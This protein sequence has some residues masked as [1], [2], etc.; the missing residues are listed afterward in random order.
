MK[1]TRLKRNSIT[2]AISAALGIMASSAVN[3]EE[4]VERVSIIG[5][6]I[7][8]SASSAASPVDVIGSEYI[9]RS[10]AF[11][12]GEITAKLGVNSGSENQADSFTAGYTQGTSNVNLRGLGLSST[13][14]LINGRRQTV[15]ATIANDGS[16]FVDTSTIP[17]AALE[18][19]EI[20]KE[21]AASAYGSD[22]VAGVVNYI[23][24]KDFDGFEVNAGYQTT[25]DDNQDTKEASF[26]WG[27]GNN[28]TW[29][30]IAGAMM[31]Q[32]PLSV[33]DRP[34]IADNAI[35]TL[36]RSFILLGSDTVTSGDYA[37]TYTPG[38]NVPDP[39]CVDNGGVLIPQ[40]S[41]AR[42]GFVYGPRYNIVNEEERNQL[43]TNV[44][45]DLSDTLILTAELGYSEHEVVDNPQSPSYPNLSFPV[46]S[47]GQAGSPFGVPVVWL[48]RPLG[49]EAPS[50]LAPR[51]NE[52]W[53]AVLELDGAFNDNWS[54][55]GAVTYSSNKRDTTQP[56]TIDSR[57]KAALAGTGGGSGTETFNIFDPSQNSAELIDYISDSEETHREADLTV[58]DFV[59]TGDLFEMDAGYVGFAAGFQY[60]DESLKITRNEIAT[61]TIDPVTGD[62]I[63]IDLIFLGGGFPTNVN[64]QS[65]AVFA[66]MQIPL[67]DTLEVG[68]AARYEDLETASSLDP[69]F[70]VRWQATDELVLRGSVSTAFREASLA[71]L[72]TVETSLQG[73]Q[74]FNPDGTS[75]GGLSFV[76]VTAAG[77]QDLD[78]EQSINSNFGAIW[79]PSNNFD[80][81]IDYWAF[82]YEDVITV[83]NAQ[84]KIANDLNG[85]DIFRIAGD[86]STLTGISSNY[87]NAANV[88]TDGID[89][90]INYSYPS[91]LGEF[92]AHFTGTHTLSYE[93]PDASGGTQDVTGLFNQD[94]FARSLPQT[95]ANLALDWTMDSHSAAIITYYVASYET[96]RAVPANAS[97]NI[98]AW[99]T[100]DMQ[101]SYNLEIADSKAVVTVGMKN[102][103]DENPPVVYDA[104]NLSYDPKHHDPRG[105][106]FYVRAKYRF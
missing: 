84:G 76:R 40:G 66:E 35:S 20:L 50:P 48:G 33:A 13:L 36:G 37:G 53:R 101:Y 71:Q 82:E 67:T 2:L 44:T 6:Y 98:D 86:N 11:T 49:S 96:T 23:L 56:D 54:W 25:A 18:R 105:Q 21:G 73:I 74:D 72:N 12:V 68:V 3:A 41:G 24:K 95:K 78:P 42:C 83:E 69:K 32:D 9:N 19:V 94:N 100:V 10:G 38:E 17:I 4:E 29:V 1:N 34:F 75:K 65:Y 46:V 22:A 85:P 30:T 91:S 45:H 57:L 93:I 97:A 103:F 81:R 14:V 80:M 62:A 26:L 104:A 52:T 63:A 77:N 92:G 51:E 16:V 55:N 15:A 61:Q 88:Y 58:F 43:Y 89:L 99:I 5:S 64:R 90:A 60:R 106:M 39:N 31:R 7:K 8:S 102:V 27:F 59:T 47:P 79:T 87:I 28:K 70:S